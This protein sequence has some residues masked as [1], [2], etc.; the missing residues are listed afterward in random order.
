MKIIPN[1]LNK[2]LKCHF[3]GTTKSVKYTIELHGAICDNKPLEVCVCNK[4]ALIH[5]QRSDNNAE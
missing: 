4:C 3:C 5:E 1:W 2:L